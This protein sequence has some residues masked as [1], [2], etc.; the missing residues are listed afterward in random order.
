MTKEEAQAVRQ[1]LMQILMQGGT[2]S[3][4]VLAYMKRDQGCNEIQFTDGGL[5]TCLSGDGSRRVITEKGKQ[6]IL[7]MGEDI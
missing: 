2:V 1:V 5:V 3:C 6:F 4:R 7:D